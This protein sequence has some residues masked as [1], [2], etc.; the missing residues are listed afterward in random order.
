MLMR[1]LNK[2]ED[3]LDVLLKKSLKDV[4]YN[5]L[6]TLKANLR[7]IEA[8]DSKLKK[9]N[10]KILAKT[11]DVGN[12]IEDEMV[13]ANDIMNTTLILMRKLNEI[14]EKCEEN[15]DEAELAPSVSPRSHGVSLKL[16]KVDL[17]KFNGQYK[18]WTP[19][20]DLFNNAVDNNGSL[21]DIQKFYFLKAALTDEP[22]RLLA[23]LQ[24]TGSNYNVAKT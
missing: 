15:D 23:H 12:A 18:N 13:E 21:P 9:L 24:V 20:I 3:N 17:P 1:T 19:F 16:P 4:T 14:I 8:I 2:I 7:N 11:E 22:S 5:D 10:P 6:L